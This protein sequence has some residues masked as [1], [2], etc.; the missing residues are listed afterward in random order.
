MVDYNV[1]FS[2]GRITIPSQ[3]AADYL[4]QQGEIKPQDNAKP[5]QLLLI[6]A[7]LKRS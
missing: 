2:G 1:P 7:R 4:S 5:Q 3:A 6:V